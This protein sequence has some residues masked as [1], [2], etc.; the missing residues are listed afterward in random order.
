MTGIET[1]FILG[2]VGTATQL[3]G[4]LQQAS[5]IKAAGKAQQQQAEYQA[6][7][8][9]IAAGQEMASGQRDALEQGRRTRLAQSRATAIAA[10]QGGTMD[11]SFL[12]I[13]SALESEGQYAKDFALFE[14][15]DRASQLE[16][17]SDLLKY[18]G[19]NARIAANTEAKSKVMSTL[20]N[21]A[22]SAG[23]LYSKYGGGSETIAWNDGTTGTYRRTGK[24]L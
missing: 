14:S 2:A 3:V 21:T 11:N 10:G 13:M 19:K 1:A 24:Y 16:Q 4:G 5:A 23:T 20:T 6:K 8:A 15:K 18:E 22:M 7:Q 12:N 9:Q 17:Q